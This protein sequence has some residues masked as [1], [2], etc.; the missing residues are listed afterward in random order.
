MKYYLA[1]GSNLNF[2]E[3]N[4]RCP[5]C[6]LVGKKNLYGKELAFKGSKVGY[7]TLEDASILKKTPVGIFEISDKDE[8]SLDFYEGYPD[9]YSKEYI[10]FL[11]KGKI[12]KG[13]YY[14]INSNFSYQEPTSE[15]FYDCL[16]GYIDFG[17]NQESLY[18]ALEKCSRLKEKSKIKKL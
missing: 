2:Q 10:S 12:I 16:K 11:F 6:K 18:D 13:L 1:Y 7:L 17:F 3:M 14:V 15:Y 5:D 4:K 8:D 9:L